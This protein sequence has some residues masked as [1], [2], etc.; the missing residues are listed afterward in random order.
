MNPLSER[1]LQTENKYIIAM[2]FEH[3][4]NIISVEV[5]LFIGFQTFGSS[6]MLKVWCVSF[7]V[8]VT[9]RMLAS[10]TN[11]LNIFEFDK[12]ASAITTYL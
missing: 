5:I 2:E 6:K 12:K 10:P 8:N 7:V 9:A 4:A 3:K 11:V 1:N